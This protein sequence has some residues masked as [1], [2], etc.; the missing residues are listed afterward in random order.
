V[1]P[2]TAV[3]LKIIFV[4]FGQTDTGPMIDVGAGGTSLETHIVLAAL[5][6]LPQAGLIARTL[7]T[8]PLKLVL[9]FTNMLLPDEFPDIVIPAGSVHW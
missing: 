9:V 8:P 6:V 3:T 4:E 1:Y 2:A 5:G 7:M